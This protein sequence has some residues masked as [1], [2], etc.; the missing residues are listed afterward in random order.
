MAGHYSPRSTGLASMALATSGPT[1]KLEHVSERFASL[2][3]D[4]ETEKQNRKQAETSRF[5]MLN[6][7]VQRLEKG[8]EAEVKRRA[9]SD[10]QLQAH[11][12]G[13]LAALAERSA[14]Q[15]AEVQ[16]S[17]KQGIE[18][19][20]NRMQDLHAI[21]REE[22]E[23]RRS[24]VE[25]LATSLVSK[26]NEC[27]SALDEERNNRVQDQSISLKRFGEDLIGL[28]SR[29]D[30]ERLTRDAELSGLRSE[31]HEAL[32]NRNVSDEQF[33]A[34]QLEREERIAEDD[35]IVQ[36]INDYTKAL[37]EGLKL[38]KMEGA[39]DAVSAVLFDAINAVRTYSRL[40]AVPFSRSLAAVAQAH[41]AEL[42]NPVTRAAVPGGQCSPHSWAAW[43]GAPQCCFDG[44]Q[45]N[46]PCMWDKPRQLTQYQ[47]NGF[48]ILAMLVGSETTVP[49]EA[50]SMWA[51][52]PQHRVVVLSQGPWGAQPWGALGCAVA[53]AAD[54]R[55]GPW[56]G[57]YAA[58]WFGYERDSQGP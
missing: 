27:V 56:T 10:R 15:H 36:A 39:V 11:F 12:E 33:Q 22:R 35:E 44:T 49:N 25:H 58:C 41:V 50:A 5:Q 32:G 54:S 38:V 7:A 13:E 30:Q 3:T 17:L 57:W 21:V 6:E 51:S 23:Q 43:P 28:Q 26:V 45:T 24:D 52:S 37:Q 8:M 55:S 29:L 42:A 18:S 19:L 16:G 2:W 34:L 31:V 40:P 4:L 9:E 53:R 1:A 20:S 14:V 47:G 46:G 48:E